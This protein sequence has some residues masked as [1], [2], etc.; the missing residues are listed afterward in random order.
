[1]KQRYIIMK[2]GTTSVIKGAEKKV[3]TR[4]YKEEKTRGDGK[5]RERAEKSDVIVITSINLAAEIDLGKS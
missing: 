5:G 1:M 2:Q 4:R 3:K